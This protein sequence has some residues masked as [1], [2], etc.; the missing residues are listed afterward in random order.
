MYMSRRQ[1]LVA[2][3]ALVSVF[4]CGFVVGKNMREVPETEKI[5]DA[6]RKEARVWQEILSRSRHQ[7]RLRKLKSDEL[8]RFCSIYPFELVAFRKDVTP[9]GN[10][11]ILWLP[12]LEREFPPSGE[13]AKSLA[14]ASRW[15]DELQ[16]HYLEVPSKR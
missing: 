9:D 12:S 10:V 2:L 13:Q 4:S 5:R 1:I 6:W 8:V 14:A 11:G 15:L 16:F 7:E 3:V